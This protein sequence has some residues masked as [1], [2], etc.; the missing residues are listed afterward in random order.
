MQFESSETDNQQGIATEVRNGTFIVIPAFN[1]A[2]TIGG[3]IRALRQHY[4]N[5]VVIDDGS[6]DDTHQ[7]ARD[8]GA[9]VLRHVLNRGQGAALQTG[10][11]FALRRDAQYVVTFDADGQHRVN[12]IA[13]LLAPIVSGNVEISLGSRFLG[14]AV[15][16]PPLRRAVLWLAVRFTRMIS[17]VVLTDTHNGLRAFSRQAAQMID[18][19]NDRM[20]HA[21]ELIDIIRGSGLPF[22][23][24]PVKIRYTQHTLAKGQSLRGAVRI[25]FDYF[26]GRVAL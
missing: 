4:P 16:I 22:A 25:A 20:A 11:E 10:I 18:I 23:E 15:R 13:G 17:G 6:V 14:K 21:S 12:D 3:V 8:A 24:V 26:V 7:V 9:M 2:G 1:E 19:R 5:V